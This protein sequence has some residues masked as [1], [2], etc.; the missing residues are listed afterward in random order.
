[1]KNP[2]VRGTK[3]PASPIRKLKPYADRAVERGIKILRMNIGQPDIETPLNMRK[4]LKNFDKT[5]IGYGPSQGLDEYQ[6]G[7]VGYYERHGI[8]LDREDIIVTTGGSEAIIMGFSVCCDPGD[9]VLIP[10]PFYTNYNGF[11]VAAGLKVKPVTT[12]IEDNWQLPEIEE[13]EALLTP[14]TKAFMLCN[15]NNPTGKVYPEDEV[16][17]LAYLA[18][19]HDLFLFGDEVYREF[20]FS[21]ETHTSILDMPEIEENAVLFDSISKRFSACGARIGAFVT[22]NREISQAALKFGQARL[23]PPTVDQILAIPSLSLG[24]EYFD[25]IR[26]EYKKRRDTVLNALS[27]IE[28]VEFRVPEGAFYITV[29][30]PVQNAEHFV[31][32]LLS[33]Y[34]INGETLMLAP[35]EGFYATPGLGRNEVRIAFVL[36]NEKTMRA[37]NILKKGLTEY[38]SAH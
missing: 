29:K 21:G 6:R 17:K 28:D 22:R 38:V 37:M 23:C 35:A 26:E 15:P 19:K 32:W 3:F 2:S 7:L 25:N 18:K 12:R 20:I 4:A 10:E 30:L 14:K 5:V 24:K 27:E 31:I 8:N 11:A 36:D 34:E 9:E 13:I 33:E 16:K 1:M